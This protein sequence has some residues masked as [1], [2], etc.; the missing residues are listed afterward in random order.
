MPI[1]QAVTAIWSISCDRTLTAPYGVWLETTLSASYTIRLGK[2]LQDS[3]LFLPYGLTAEPAPLPISLEASLSRAREMRGAGEMGV[4]CESHFAS[5]A[6]RLHAACSLKIVCDSRWTSQFK[7][8]RS[9]NSVGVTASAALSHS[10]GVIT[11]GERSS[12]T[13]TSSGRMV[14]VKGSLSATAALSI[15]MR[16]RAGFPPRH[17]SLTAAYAIRYPVSRTLLLPYSCGTFISCRLSAQW[18]SQVARQLAVNWHIGHFVAPRVIT[19]SWK[20]TLGNRLRAP[21]GAPLSKSLVAPYG[22]TVQ[23]SLCC[24][25]ALR[26]QLHRALMADWS[27]TLPVSAHLGAQWQLAE[28]NALSTSITAWWDLPAPQPPITAGSGLKV[29]HFG[30]IL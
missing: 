26:Q 29:I 23:Q 12:L 19:A 30:Q 10:I 14:V 2:E 15:Q 21:Y 28:Y 1:S 3:Y 18:S 17:Q 7:T 4:R 9:D 11:Q 16:A 6:H 27:K 25:Y 8:L 5:T 20:I 22:E 13:V 24:R